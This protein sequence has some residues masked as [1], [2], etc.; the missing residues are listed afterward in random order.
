MVIAWLSLACAPH[1]PEFNCH[2][3]FLNLTCGNH[4]LS[5][6]LVAAG[7][8]FSLS[9]VLCSTESLALEQAAPMQD[10]NRAEAKI[11]ASFFS[12]CEHFHVLPHS[13]EW[14]ASSGQ[15]VSWYP[16][17]LGARLYKENGS[18]AAI[19]SI[20]SKSP[21]LPCVPAQCWHNLGQS[22]LLIQVSKGL[23]LVAIVSMFSLCYKFHCLA[24]ISFSSNLC[25]NAATPWL[26]NISSLNHSFMRLCESISNLFLTLNSDPDARRARGNR[27]ARPDAVFSLPSICWL[28]SS[29][30]FLNE[31]VGGLSLP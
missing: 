14:R 15:S 11:H 18:F 9:P 3:A 23:V 24:L 27:E 10:T 26:R 22:E 19:C 4:L 16:A 7:C 21:V 8:F 25:E 6:S 12:A 2:L 31:G 29:Q 13:V 20:Q 28:P 1:K 5:T 17:T 30:P